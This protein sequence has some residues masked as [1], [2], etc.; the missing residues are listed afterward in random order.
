[1]P[2]D[3]IDDIIRVA[4][5][6]GAIGS[7]QLYWRHLH[8]PC[9][10]G[11]GGVVPATEKSEGDGATPAGLFGLDTLYFRADRLERPE[12]RLPVKTITKNLGWCDDPGAN[13]YNQPVKLPTTSRAEEMWQEDSVYDLVISLTHN[14]NP[15]RRGPE[16][17]NGSA[18][19]IHIAR[20]DLSPTRGCIAL[21][22]NDLLSLLVEI[23]P[24]TMIRTY[25]GSADEISD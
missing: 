19:F 13:A 7:G 16:P 14:R 10:L 6:G 2:E 12:T 3:F 11:R 4:P 21:A 24:E 17:G 15:A 23:G 20:D 18:I 5:D 9:V 25:A 1:M 8:L 22:R